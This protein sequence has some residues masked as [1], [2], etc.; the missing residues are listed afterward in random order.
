[1]AVFALFIWAALMTPPGP[2]RWLSFGLAMAL[3]CLSAIDL[4]VF[5]LP[6]VFTLPLLGAGLIAAV[7]LPGR[8]VLDHGV[9]ALIGWSVLTAFAWGYRRLRG[10][11]GM[12]LGDAKLLGAAGAWLGAAALPSVV[13]L[14]CALSLLGV[15]LR[16]VI[17]GRGSVRE[18]I[19][20]GPPLC[21]ATWVV[22]LHGPLTT[23]G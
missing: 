8:P 5:R 18:R 19:A 2:I 15:G 3:A 4:T 10:I 21:L 13:L 7:F 22:W 14:A 6:D 17:R 1:M 9:G 23:R 20:F 11:D 16:A 12:G